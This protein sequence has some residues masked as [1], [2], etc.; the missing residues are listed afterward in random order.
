MPIQNYHTVKPETN[1]T[2]LHY[3]LDFTE[4]KLQALEK[5]SFK[6]YFVD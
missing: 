1:K 2:D 3:I 6:P 5:H 4:C